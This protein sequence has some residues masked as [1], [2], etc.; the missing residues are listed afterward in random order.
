MCTVGPV[1]PTAR[2]PLIVVDGGDATLSCARRPSRDAAPSG[3]TDRPLRL[4]RHPD[5]ITRELR[6]QGRLT[7]LARGV[8]GVARKRPRACIG[9]T[10]DGSGTL[11]VPA[12]SQ[13]LVTKS[14]FETLRVPSLT[15]MVSPPTD[16]MARGEV[17]SSWATGNWSSGCA[18]RSVASAA[19]SRHQLIRSAR[20]GGMD[21]SR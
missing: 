13:R 14:K 15:L 7:A 19:A 11:L 2:S 21:A 8:R 9:S 16:V 6:N 12:I 3:V 10:N 18:Q 1:W 20:A 4:E 5:T 17:A